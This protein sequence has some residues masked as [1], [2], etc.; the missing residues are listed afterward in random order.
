MWNSLLDFIVDAQD[1]N[2]FKNRLTKTMEKYMF[3][4]EM[5][6]TISNLMEV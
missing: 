3:R 2:V 1:I 4:L 5:I 6:G